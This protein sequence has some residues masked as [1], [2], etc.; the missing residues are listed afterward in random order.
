MATRCCRFFWSG[1][2][3]PWDAAKQYHCAV[4]CLS[5]DLPSS[6][7]RRDSCPLAPIPN[8]ANIDAP[9]LQVAESSPTKQF[10]FKRALRTAHHRRMHIEEGKPVGA[11][12]EMEHRLLDQVK[13]MQTRDFSAVLRRRCLSCQQPPPRPPCY[14]YLWA[15]TTAQVFCVHHM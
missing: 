15:L 6:P 2:E 12:L 5:N 13:R 9:V 11:A 1:C 3:R 14:T 8:D 7:V 10:L 4:C